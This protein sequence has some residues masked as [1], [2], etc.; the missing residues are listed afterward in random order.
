MPRQRADQDVFTHGVHKSGLVH[1][2][3]VPKPIIEGKVAQKGTFSYNR[4]T[5]K[6]TL[7]TTDPLSFLSPA[8]RRIL[9]VLLWG[10]EP[11][12]AI[13]TDLHELS[14]KEVV[15]LGVTLQEKRDL[16]WG[17][18]TQK[19]LVKGSNALERL[20]HKILHIIRMREEYAEV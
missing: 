9:S 5:K 12:D 6:F 15:F 10:L 20:Y 13:Y 18:V 4:K 1:K 2:I 11:Y 14:E 3:T 16:E 8:G 19:E 17:H 7:D